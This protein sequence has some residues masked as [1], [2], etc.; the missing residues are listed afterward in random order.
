VVLDAT[1]LLGND[2]ASKLFW[3]ILILLLILSALH[4]YRR[5]IESTKIKLLI[6]AISIVVGGGVLLLFLIGGGYSIFVGFPE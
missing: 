1:V 2:M 3:M 6:K 5:N 4:R